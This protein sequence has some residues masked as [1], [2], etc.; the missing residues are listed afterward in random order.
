MADHPSALRDWLATETLDAR[1]V[2][3]ACDQGL[4]PL[5]FYRLRESDMLRCLPADVVTALHASYYATAAQHTL[6]SAALHALLAELGLHGVQ[7][8]VLKGMALSSTLYPTPATRPTSDL[9]LLIERSQMTVVKQALL[10][11][12]YRDHLGLAPE[13]HLAFT[14]HLRMQRCYAGKQAVSVEAHWELVH[15]PGYVQYLA[16]DQFRARA[17]L[18]VLDGGPARV[19]EPADQLLHACA[20]LLL[21]HSQNP[22]LVWLLDLRLIVERYGTI[23]DWVE[24]VRRAS[25][26]HVAAALCYWLAQA[27][28]WFGAFLPES[29]RQAL[30]AVVQPAEGEARYIA[31]AQAGNLRVWAFYRQLVGGL[32]DWRQ[33]LAHIRETLFPPWAY[34]QNRYGARSRW[35][36]PLYYGWRLVRAGRV[37]FR[38]VG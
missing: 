36:A 26:L 28:G 14:N 9:D 38:R 24:L 13:D 33:R 16:A 1:D 17:Q 37:A 3:W 10:R 4:A 6:M 20:H 21:H 19:L 11:L 23:W 12:G 15:N 27:E 7:P 8:I 2:A 29:A 25:T 34:M 35:A 18:A 5:I 32:A 31:A 22:R 30:A